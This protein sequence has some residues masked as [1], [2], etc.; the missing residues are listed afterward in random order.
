MDSTTP[1]E[2]LTS[3]VGIKDTIMGYKFI[4]EG[5]PELK[6]IPADQRRK[7]FLSA[8]AKDGRRN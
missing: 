7:R 5:I 3:A 2:S 4:G 1:G 6:E 8:V